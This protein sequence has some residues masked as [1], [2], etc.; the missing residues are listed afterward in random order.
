MS[1]LERLDQLKYLLR[2][3]ISYHRKREQYYRVL[4]AFSKA[5]SLA[6]LAAIGF[7]T[8]VYTIALAA[9]SGGLTIITI[10]KDCSTMAATH[11]SLAQEFIQLLSNA[12]ILKESDQDFA[13][14]V[15]QIEYDLHLLDAQEPPIMPGLQQLCQDEIDYADGAKVESDRLSLLRRIKAQFGFGYKASLES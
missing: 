7:Q 15:D 12:T 4:D 10:V 8:N 2:I 1:Q 9:I 13:E 6:A 11:R 5:L 3:S 14:S